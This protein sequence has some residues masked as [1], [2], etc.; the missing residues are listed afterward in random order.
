MIE[1]HK[2][3]VMLVI[4]DAMARPLIEAYREGDY[5]ASSLVSL[6]SSAA[7]FSPWSRRP[8][9]RRCPTC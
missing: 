8:A 3:N 2:V 9:P 5:D 6:S 1:Q 7:L 4:G